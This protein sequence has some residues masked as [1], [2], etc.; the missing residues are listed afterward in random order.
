LGDHADWQ[1]FLRDAVQRNR[2]WDQ[3]VR[4]ILHP[5][6]DD[7]AT[8]GAALWYTKRLE[9][10]GQN[11]VDIPGLV[12]D[13]G[14]HFLGIDVQCAQCHDHLFVGDCR[15]FIT[16]RSRSGHATIRT[17]LKFPAVGPVAGQNRSGVGFV[18]QLLAVGPNP[19]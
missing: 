10:Y 13:V 4:V 7:E 2:P 5:N 14:R 18:K 17:D 16:G 19:G 3:I 6:P 11:P 15:S 12:R 1:K 9:N 8:R